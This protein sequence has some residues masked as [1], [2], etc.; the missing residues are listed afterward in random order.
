[1]MAAITGATISGSSNIVCTSFWPRNP[2]L[3]TSARQ[4]PIT[5]AP[6][7]LKAMNR[8]VLGSTTCRN[9]GSVMTSV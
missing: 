8:N 3:N 1:M 5:S 6:P 7:T 9:A 2:R 4:S